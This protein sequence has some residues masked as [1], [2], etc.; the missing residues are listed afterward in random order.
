MVG[1]SMGVRVD[2]WHGILLI[3]R[4][5]VVR[6]IVLVLLVVEVPTSFHGTASSTCVSPARR[7]MMN[8]TRCAMVGDWEA[9]GERALALR[10]LRRIMAWGW[11][12][13][14]GSALW[15][16]KGCGHG[17]TDY[18]GVGNMR[19]GRCRGLRQLSTTSTWRTGARG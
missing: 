4:W 15:P 3:C 6:L 11:H 10:R 9:S 17:L 14:L 2:N 13:S 8:M 18:R 16:P 19:P 7:S 12:W 1:Q 5:F